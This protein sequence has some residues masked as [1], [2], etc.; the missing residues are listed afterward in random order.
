MPLLALGFEVLWR[1]HW[2]VSICPAGGE[3]EME[4]E[5]DTWHCTA[6]GC[7]FVVEDLHAVLG[8]THRAN[9]MATDKHHQN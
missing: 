6:C 4:R 8:A 5:F 7:W 2:P 3:H 1:P 9:Q